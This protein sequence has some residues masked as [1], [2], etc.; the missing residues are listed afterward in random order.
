MKLNLTPTQMLDL[1]PLWLLAALALAKVQ[2]M[3]L[4]SLPALPATGWSLVA[5]AAALMLL[6]LRQF[7]AARTSVVPHQMP[8]AML[9]TG[10]YRYSRNP[11]YL[12]DL[13]LLAGVSLVWGAWLGLM[14]VPVL[15]AILQRRFIE[16]EERRLSTAFPESFERYRK[17]TR[18]WV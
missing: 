3:T 13:I 6:A 1:P 17:Q 11:I 7:R 14:L 4:P 18:R 5:L 10:V 2:T 15:K 9:S 8:A 12:A 16:P